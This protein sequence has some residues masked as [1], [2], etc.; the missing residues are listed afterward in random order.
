LLNGVTVVRNL[1]LEGKKWNLLIIFRSQIF[2]GVIAGN[3]LE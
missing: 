2:H 1:K 3:K